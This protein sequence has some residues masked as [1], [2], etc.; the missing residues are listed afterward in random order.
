MI[1]SGSFHLLSSLPPRLIYTSKV[2][3]G[4]GKVYE[5]N[6]Y[7]SLDVP[8]SPHFPPQPLPWLLTL[9]TPSHLSCHWHSM[10]LEPL[11]HL[12]LVLNISPSVTFSSP[13]L[14]SIIP[15]LV[16]QSPLFINPPG[17][18]PSLPSKSFVTH[19]SPPLD[20]A[21]LCVHCLATR[22]LGTQLCVYLIEE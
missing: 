20:W 15:C 6:Q 18:N 13:P 16:L 2:I 5:I 8:L 17:P 12:G 9:K 14:Q 10:C 19:L 22:V 21:S 3:S 7:I 11:L 1:Y 4:L